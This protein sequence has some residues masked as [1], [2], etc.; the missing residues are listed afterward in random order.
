MVDDRE[1]REGWTLLISGPCAA[2]TPAKPLNSSWELL[3]TQ[4]TQ[5]PDW[6]R[7]DEEAARAAHRTARLERERKAAHEKGCAVR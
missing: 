2:L 6:T 3:P 5:P 4:Q 1:S 7:E